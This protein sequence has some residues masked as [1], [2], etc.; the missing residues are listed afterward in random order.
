MRAVVHDRYGPPDVLRL[1]EVERPVPEDDEV[2]V[3]VH[4]TTVTRTD[5]GFRQPRP[6]FV[7]FFSGLLRP[8]HRILGSELAGEVEAVG[9]AVSEFAVGDQ[10]FGV[11]ADRFGAHAE[12]VCM[13]EHAPLAHKPAGL[14]F[15]EAAAVCDGATIALACLRGARLPEGQTILV[16]ARPDRSEPRPCSWPSTWAPRSPPSA[17]RRTSASSDRSAQTR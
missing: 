7:R 9:A 12:F 4:A 2:L 16:Y 11:N 8:S 1:E 3:R 14:S 10:V 15:E 6:F 13:R 17:T 5:C